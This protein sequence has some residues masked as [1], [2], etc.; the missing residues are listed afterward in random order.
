MRCT[1]H[2][3]HDTANDLATPAF[4]RAGLTRRGGNAR[5]PVGRIAIP[6]DGKIRHERCT[7]SADSTA[8]GGRP[9]C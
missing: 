1:I 7:T 3:T 4:T 9:E 6:A 2:T 8:A 5:A